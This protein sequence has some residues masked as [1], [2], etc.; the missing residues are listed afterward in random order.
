MTRGNILG[1]ILAE[2][3]VLFLMLFKL[4]AAVSLSASFSTSTAMPPTF[5]GRIL[6][7]LIWI[8]APRQAASIFYFILFTSADDSFSLFV[9]SDSKIIVGFFLGAARLGTGIGANTCA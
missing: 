1:I 9:D 2:K 4:F 8:L 6:I 3:P 7:A 5:V